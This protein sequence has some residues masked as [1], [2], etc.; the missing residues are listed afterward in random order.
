[1]PGPKPMTLEIHYP[2]GETETRTLTTKPVKLVRSLT[3]LPGATTIGFSLSGA[4]APG[5]R[6]I[7][8]PRIEQPTLTEQALVPFETP[9]HGLP[10]GLIEAGFAPPPCL[11]TVEAVR[12]RRLMESVR[13]IVRPHRVALAA[14]LALSA[15]LNTY[16][17]SQNA[18]GN[19][20]YSAGVKSMLGSLHNFLFVSFDQGG[21]VTID[22]PP[23]GVWPQA[24][25]A[26]LFGFTPLSLLLAGG[27]HRNAH[28]VG[29]LPRALTEV[30]CPRRP[31]GGARA[32]RLPLVGGRV[33]RQRRGPAARAVDAARLRGCARGDPKRALALAD[34]LGGVRGAGLQHEDACRLPGGAGDRARLPRVRARRVVPTRRQ[35]ARGG[36]GDGSRV[37]LVDRAGRSR[38][39]LAATV[40]GELHQQHRDGAHVRIQR[41]GTCGRRGRGPRQRR[42]TRGR[43]G[44]RTHAPQAAE[45]ARRTGAFARRQA[46]CG[47]GGLDATCPTA[48]TATRSPSAARSARCACSTPS[49]PDKAPGCCR[50]RCSAC[51]RS[52]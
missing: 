39:R 38:P 3:V 49:S 11:Q 36:R 31:W 45:H 18:W 44:R 50:S 52:R 25:S 10:G 33:A 17:L 28:R 51:L 21:L 41:V 40:R 4:P 5:A 47:E 7:E 15:F 13:K 34:R 1:M 20:F 2:G 9:P 32:R 26:K 23:L 29:A 24:V 35:A 37:L 6:R 48:A 12:S 22:K 30:G 16:K 46:P 27:A 19:T 14:I 42:Q 8:G 43:C